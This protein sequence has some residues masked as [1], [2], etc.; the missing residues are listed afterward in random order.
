LFL[1]SATLFSGTWNDGGYPST[2]L[3]L[4]T[5][6]SGIGGS[7]TGGAGVFSFLVSGAFSS[8]VWGGCSSGTTG[9]FS[10]TFAAGVSTLTGVYDVGSATG[11]GVDG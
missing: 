11:A 5:G 8:L 2:G 9:S 6:S 1:M 4:S 10:G 3:L 7:E